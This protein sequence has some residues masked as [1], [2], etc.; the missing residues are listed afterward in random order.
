MSLT[1]NIGRTC[2]VFGENYLL[3]QRVAKLHPHRQEDSPLVYWMFRSPETRQK[4]EQIANG[5]AQQNLSP[6]Q[7]GKM[8]IP[9]PTESVRDTYAE[10]ASPMVDAILNLNRKNATLRTTRDLLLPKLISGKLDVED[11]DIDVG[12]TA[13]ALEEATE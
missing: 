1:G 12:M 13:E 8:A 11:L 2:L 3:N 9:I 4:L 6:V 10:V 5:V 7:T